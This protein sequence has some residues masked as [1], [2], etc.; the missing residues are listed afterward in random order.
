MLLVNA[1]KMLFDLVQIR[2]ACEYANGCLYNDD[3]WAMR[4]GECVYIITRE[5]SVVVHVESMQIFVYC[6]IL[7]F[8]LSLWVDSYA[9]GKLDYLLSSC[10]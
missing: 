7:G 2:Q 8:F 9:E 10:L 5:R 6:E 4:L 3:A 1:G